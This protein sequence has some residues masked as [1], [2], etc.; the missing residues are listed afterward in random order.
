MGLSKQLRNRQSDS[1]AVNVNT[2]PG[3]GASPDDIYV[4]YDR[5]ELGMPGPMYDLFE[6]LRAKDLTLTGLVEARED[7]VMGCTTS[8]SPGADDDD[9]KRLAD[10][11]EEM[12]HELDTD[13]LLEHQ[14]HNTNFNG[15]AATELEWDERNGRAV[16]TNLI[17]P[18]CRQFRIATPINRWVDGAESDELV[19][20]TDH[21]QYERLIPDKWLVTRRRGRTRPLY[22]SGLMF[23]TAV[24][25]SMK[26]R[27]QY[28]W[29]SFIERFGL[30]LVQASIDSWADDDAAESAELT[31]KT[32]GSTNGIITTR[33]DR[34]ELSLLDGAKAAR[35]ANSDVHL[36]FAQFCN[37]DMAK[38]WTGGYLTTE[39]GTS[40]GSYAQANVHKGVK[41]SLTAADKRRQG[42][43]LNRLGSI[44]KRVNQLPGRAPRAEFY[45]SQV[46]N[47]ASAPVLAK[48]MAEAGAPVDPQQL[49]DITGFRP[50][51]N[52]PPL[53]EPLNQALL[54]AIASAV[55][56][57]MEETRA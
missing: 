30:P 44:Y 56:T 14:Q 18:R 34:V 16:I 17:H 22:A 40:A 55:R 46:S 7:A 26:S 50:P 6:D 11:F 41:D 53:G 23:V 51:E 5:A 25:S 4:L 29:M 38:V 3:R 9:S 19:L 27:T 35:S 47:P 8:I 48:Q 12:F 32:L 28:D 20:Q 13:G 31:L 42:K 43:M 45:P 54:T 39:T 52:A 21:G 49:Y 33:E 24:M 15:F 10:E 57:A 1:R 36:R 2:H 37:L